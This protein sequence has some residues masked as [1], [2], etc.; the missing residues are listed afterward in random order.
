MIGSKPLKSLKLSDVVSNNK[1][2]NIF[3]LRYLATGKIPLLSAKDLIPQ[4]GVNYIPPLSLKLISKAPIKLSTSLETTEAK[5][6]PLE[7]SWNNNDHVRQYKGERLVNII[8]KPD[9]QYM[10]GSCWAWAVATS[11][12]D[13]IGIY[14]GV[15][16]QLGPSYLLSWSV[17]PTYEYSNLDGCNGGVL[18]EGLMGMTTTTKSPGVSNTCWNYSWCKNNE[19]CNPRDDST[20][21]T[22]YSIMNSIIP[23]YN[24]FRNSCITA[25]GSFRP[26]Q[27]VPQSIFSLRDIDSIKLSIFNKGPIPTGYLVYTDF[28]LGSTVA[29]GEIPWKQTKGIYIHLQPNPLNLSRSIRGDPVFY[30]SLGKPEVLAHPA[31]GHAVVI[32][33]WGVQEFDSTADNFLHVSLHPNTKIQ[34]PYWIVRNSWSEQW[35][36]NGYF[37]IAMTNAQYAIN[38]DVVFDINPFNMR[39]GGGCVDFQIDTTNI[40]PA[41]LPTITSKPTEP[42]IAPQPVMPTFEHQPVQPS[43]IPQ[44]VMP[45]FEPQPVQPT[46]VPPSDNESCV[47]ICGK[48]I[49]INNSLQSKSIAPAHLNKSIQIKIKSNQS[50]SIRENYSNDDNKSNVC[51]SSYMYLFL[52]IIFIICI[53]LYFSYNKKF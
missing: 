33:G 43:T 48:D 34:I 12:S 44:P 9:N 37:K 40:T 50:K 36:E 47:I 24:T 29:Q 42:T 19:Y 25:G 23:K 38:T 26:Y 1:P 4:A 45:T 3:E 22:N 21:F 16:P 17:R 49:K 15:N 52:F 46:V 39:F 8:M 32:V 14:S 20:I 31:G 27:V 10:C 41:V 11:L 30:Q 6:L 51:Y 2:I 13:R 35:G 28:M 18:D 7:F 5:K 53:L